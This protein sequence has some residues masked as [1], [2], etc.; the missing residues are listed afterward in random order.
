MT[1]RSF[2]SRFRSGHP[3]PDDRATGIIL[4]ERS[5]KFDKFQTG[6]G[7]SGHYGRAWPG[8]VFL[9]MRARDAHIKITSFRSYGRI[10]VWRCLFTIKI[11]LIGFPETGNAIAVHGV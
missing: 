3:G 7:E 5:D 9:V 2:L 6:R 8:A 4:P 10:S 1:L 11:R